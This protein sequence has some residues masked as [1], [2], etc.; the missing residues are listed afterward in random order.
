MAAAT[1]A[2]VF[3]SRDAGRTWSRLG[4]LAVRVA[5]VRRVR[6]PASGSSLLVADAGSESF[7][8]EG[9][10]WVPLAASGAAGPLTGGLRRPRPVRQPL[11]LG[12]EVDEDLGV[13]VFRAAD[14]GAVQGT[15]P[16]TGL[17]VAGWAGDPRRPE[18]LFLATVGRGLFRFVPDAAPAP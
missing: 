9:R 2:G 18:G 5:S 6:A 11:A 17:R 14:G 13:F 8:W 16:E 4:T 10:E 7:A 3:E 12:L 15:L 1:E